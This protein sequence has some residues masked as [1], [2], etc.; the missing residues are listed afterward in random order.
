MVR[1]SDGTE[2]GKNREA[3]LLNAHFDSALGGP[4]AGDSAVAVATLMEC[5]R[6][7][8]ASSP[9]Y[10]PIIFLFNGAG[11]SL[12]FF[13]LSHI[14]SLSLTEEPILDGS[15]GFIKTHPWAK[16]I[17][18]VLNFDAAGTRMHCLFSFPFS[19]VNINLLYLVGHTLLFQSGRADM[20][21][22][23]AA[24]VKMVCLSACLSYFWLTKTY[25]LGSRMEEFLYKISL[26][27]DLFPAILIIVYSEI[28]ESKA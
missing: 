28:Q 14:F 2:E 8:A 4:G 18:A 15:D 10:Y 21:R 12:S 1:L 7:H 11:N 23:Y 25:L 16:N 27:V 19:G 17:Q 6:A 22:A 24:S 3:L 20:L 26:L 9:P 13:S 5:V